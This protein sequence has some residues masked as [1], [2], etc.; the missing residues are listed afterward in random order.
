MLFFQYFDDAHMGDTKRSTTGQ[1][2]TGLWA[3]SCACL[4]H[5]Q[6]QH[7]TQRDK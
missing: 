4:W 3:R 2:Q 5:R 1:H 7:Q 6:Y